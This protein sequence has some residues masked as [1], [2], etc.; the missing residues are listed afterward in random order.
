MKRKKTVLENKKGK[1]QSDLLNISSTCAIPPKPP[2]SK[3]SSLLLKKITITDM[4]KNNER[5]SNEINEAMK[6][7]KK[8]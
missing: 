7:K 4:S 2:A 3:S 5:I 1:Q 8:Y 6:K